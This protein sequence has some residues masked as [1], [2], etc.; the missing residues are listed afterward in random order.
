V[1]GALFY[2]AG[3]HDS[4]GL[5]GLA[6]LTGLIS[7]MTSDL[8]QPGDWVSRGYLAGCVGF[9]AL[10][11]WSTTVRK[12]LSGKGLLLVGC[13]SYPLYLLHNELG[14]G[15]IKSAAVWLPA[16]LWPLLPWMTMA[17][18]IAAA[19]LIAGYYDG[20]ATKWLRTMMLRGLLR[21]GAARKA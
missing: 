3:Q 9:F 14:I 18:M 21:L 12:L 15:F 17:I 7:A 4:R 13:A 10:T 2:K 6:I 16:V 20:P 1:A 11:H 19:W 8:W 5:F